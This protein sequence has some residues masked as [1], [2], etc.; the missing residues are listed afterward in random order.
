MN[1]KPANPRASRPDWKTEPVELTIDLGDKAGPRLFDLREL[2]AISESDLASD[3]RG[4][5]GVAAYF[6]TLHAAASGLVRQREGDLEDT[7]SDAYFDARDALVE[8]APKKA[9]T[10]TAIK[11]MA[12]QSDKV[13]QARD[14]LSAAKLGRD[15]LA[16]VMDRLADRRGMIR[17]LAQARED[18]F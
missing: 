14:R 16:N 9:P 12:A 7:E 18:E 8:E 11:A 17:A 2:L 6:G 4:H 5:A 3:M 10:E 1:P 15:Q 13:R